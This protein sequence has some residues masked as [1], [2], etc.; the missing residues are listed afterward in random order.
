MAGAFADASLQIKINANTLPLPW[1]LDRVGNG[2]IAGAATYSSSVFSVAGAGVIAS[3]EDSGSLGW[4]TLSGAGSITARLSVL[5]NTGT[6]ARIGVMIRE[7]LAANSR[8]LFIGVDGTGKYQW[9]RRL[10]T[11]GSASKTTKTAV[12]SAAIWVRLVRAS[13]VVTAYQSTNGST[14]TKIGSSTVTLPSN[15][16]VGL[17]VSSGDK[18]LLNSSRFTNVVITP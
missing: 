5:S 14:W 13:N 18:G 10:T 16:Y 12:A 1:N 2:N 6:S 11:A 7:S 15:C 17:W 3:T 9:I 8:Q 4:Q